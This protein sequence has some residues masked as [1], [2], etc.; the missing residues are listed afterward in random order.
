[1][2]LQQSKQLLNGLLKGELGFQGFV[3]S[4]WGA[5]QSGMASALAGLDV[6]MPSSILWGDNLTI[7]V[8]NGTVP[9]SQVD[10]MVTRYGHNP[11]R[12]A[13]FFSLTIT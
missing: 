5:Q 6:A 3:V 4:D 11:T 9:E 7:G 2:Q 1:V 12:F 13:C 10:N 8:N